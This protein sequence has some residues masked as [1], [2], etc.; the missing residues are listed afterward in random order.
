MKYLDCWET[1]KI[2]KIWL[3]IGKFPPWRSHFFY[4]DTSDY[5]ADSVFINRGLRVRFSRNEVIKPG[6]HYRGILCSVRRKDE[7]RFID[8][9]EDVKI[10]MLLCGHK[11]YEKE[12]LKFLNEL[13]AHR[14][15]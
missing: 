5:L 10:K 13:E 4:F 3:K 1:V 15:G 8:A 6:F 11:D 12:C 2:N 9:I 14:E 7:H